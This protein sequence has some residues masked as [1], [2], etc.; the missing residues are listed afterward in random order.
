GTPVV[1]ASNSGGAL[2]AGTWSVIAVGLTLEGYLNGSVTGG[3]Q[4]QLTR[5]NA[6]G[7]SDQ[8][9]GGAAKPSAAATGTTTGAAGSLTATVAPLA[10]AVAYAW[11]WGAA[12]SEKLGSVTTI[13]SVVI[14]DGAVGTQT[15]ASLGAGDNS[16]NNLS[17]DGLL[18]QAF[19]GGSNAY[20]QIMPTGVAGTGTP[21]TADGAGGIVEIETALKAFWDTYR[22]SPQEIW[23]SSQ[24]AQTISRKIL[25]GTTN[26]AQRFVFNTDQAL[27]GGGVMVRTYLN[28]Y[29]M[30][31]GQT[32]DI[33]VH[34]NMPAGTILFRTTRLP[35]PLANV[36]NVTQMRMRRDYYQI[37]W[38][39]RTRRYEYGVYCDGVLQNYFPPAFGVITNIANG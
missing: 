22:L 7:S 26:S 1:T 35:Y 29:S 21:L 3:I 12:G 16:Q 33:K 4:G 8:F 18:Y 17:F 19:K 36:T 25:T 31:G 13:N 24:E 20:V 37:E 30:V 2:A 27:L 38:P 15:A 28:R 39:L 34:P 11:F 23:V 6:D 9:G 5:T 14:T 10:G 32:L